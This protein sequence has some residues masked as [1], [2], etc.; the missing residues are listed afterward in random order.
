MSEK[1][2]RA[3]KKGTE[4]VHDI[5]YTPSP[6]NI[7]VKCVHGVLSTLLADAPDQLGGQTFIRDL[8]VGSRRA[9]KAN[10]S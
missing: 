7:C 8:G 6:C 4:P 1:R 2:A 10:G 9:V 3:V 5:L